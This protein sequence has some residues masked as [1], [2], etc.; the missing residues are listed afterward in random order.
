MLEK[1][2]DREGAGSG[3]KWRFFD[4]IVVKY[5]ESVTSEEGKNSQGERLAW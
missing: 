1:M 5:L 2:F 3:Q 4:D